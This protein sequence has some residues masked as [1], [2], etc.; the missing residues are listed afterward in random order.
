VI[1]RRIDTAGSR[2]TSAAS[3]LAA[4]VRQGLM[5]AADQG[6]HVGRRDGVA[7]YIGGDEAGR[8]F[9]EIGLVVHFLVAPPTRTGSPEPIQFWIADYYT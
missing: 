3:A 5:H 2:P 8:D 1:E 9:D 6:R 4:D 7:P